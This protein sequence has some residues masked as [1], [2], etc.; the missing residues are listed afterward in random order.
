MKIV[1]REGM[2]ET[3]SSSNHSLIL[4][5]TKKCKADIKKK[6]KQLDDEYCHIFGGGEKVASKEDKCLLLAGLFDG[7]VIQYGAMKEE[8]KIF[9]K[10]LR[11]NKEKELLS[12]IKENKKEYKNNRG[13]EPYCENYFA[14]GVLID[15]TC[16][17][18][19]E[20]DKY[21]KVKLS[22]VDCL[23]D[24]RVKALESQTDKFNKA[25]E[26]I[27]ERKKELYE[28]LHKFIYEDGI[29]VPYA[30]L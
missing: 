29:I 1:I 28:K 2:F 18:K 21:F 27:E 17:F 16:D 4:T 7:M 6:D 23:K 25:E 8:Y 26:I 3:N 24:P 12:K 13:Y 10:V 15:C 9:I 14:E 20:F 22:M 11:Y 5:N 30:H 19:R